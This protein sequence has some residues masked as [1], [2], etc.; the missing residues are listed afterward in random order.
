MRRGPISGVLAGAVLA[1][2]A[3][4]GL[5]GD[6][7]PSPIDDG[8][9]PYGLLEEEPTTPGSTA[10]AD[11]PSPAEPRV[12][13]V[14]D[15]GQ[16]VAASADVAEAKGTY[17]QVQSLLDELVD[18][19]V[20][21]DRSEG[22]SNALTP[23]TRLDVVELSGTTVVVDIDIQASGQPPSADRIPL[24]IGQVVLTVTS[25]PGVEHVVFSSDDGLLEVPL[26]GGRLTSDP[27]SASDYTGLRA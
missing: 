24:V 14:D 4:C 22:L 6:G 25:L 15:D 1:A 2:C 12:F 21:S 16:L 11:R 23:E 8:D 7:A 9:V 13:W 5:P 27:V 18:G 19:P 3:G 10:G 26:P 17:A 20:E